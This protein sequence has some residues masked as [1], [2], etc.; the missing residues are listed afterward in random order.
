MP[1][2]IFVTDHLTP[3]AKEELAAYEVFEVS[4]DEVLGDAIVLI[5]WPSRAKADLLGKMRSLK[6]IQSLAAGV[7]G[8]DFKSIP[9]GVRLYSNAGAYTDSVAE[10]AWGLALGSAA[11]LHAGRKRLPPRRLR[12]KTLLV[13]GCG[14]IGSEVARMAKASFGMTII[15]VSRTFRAPGCFDERHPA[16]HLPDVI[17]RADLVVN[18]LPLTSATRSLIGRDL[19]ERAKNHVIIVNIGRGETVDEASLVKWLK[20]RPESRYATDVF[21]KRDGKEVFDSDIWEFPNFAGTIH[22]AAAQDPDAISFA[23]L[24]AAENVR[25]FLEGREALNGVDLKEYV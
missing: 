8:F 2:R 3:S 14:A 4:A 6:M 24:M 1:I 21:W 25:R 22:T 9:P 18:S 13:L 7:D 12:S 19:L 10:H 20:E 11:G 15:G 17:G 5:T 23:H 16:S